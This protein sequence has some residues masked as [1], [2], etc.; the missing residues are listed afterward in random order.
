M[1]D[2]VLAPA[3]FPEVLFGSGF[4]FDVGGGAILRVLEEPPSVLA[5]DCFGGADMIDSRLEVS[6]RTE[7]ESRWF[8][9]MRVG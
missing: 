4:V 8:M 9:R 2:W 3:K 6:E 5:Y 1:V 7:N